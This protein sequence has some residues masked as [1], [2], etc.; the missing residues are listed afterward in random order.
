MKGHFIKSPLLSTILRRILPTFDTVNMTQG[1]KFLHELSGTNHTPATAVIDY[2]VM[3]WWSLII[4][5]FYSHL[6]MFRKVSANTW[7]VTME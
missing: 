5:G 1:F 4:N 3:L 7:L 6:V 2:L